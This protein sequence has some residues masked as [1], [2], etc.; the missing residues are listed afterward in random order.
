[1][2]SV[3]RTAICSLMR[4]AR[5]V[6]SLW[7]GLT[8]SACA[9]LASGRAECFRE[10]S[11]RDDATRPGESIL[12]SLRLETSPVDSTGVAILVQSEWETGWQGRWWRYGDSLRVDAGGPFDSS[13]LRLHRHGSAVSGTVV[14]TTDVLVRDSSGVYRP[15]EDHRT[16]AATQ[17]ECG[18]L[19]RSGRLPQN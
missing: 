16:W 5:A 9:S 3:L 19:P 14:S 7:A 4:V 18:R 2:A 12:S 8:M 10:T 17:V 11:A 13:W 6:A 1:M 15:T